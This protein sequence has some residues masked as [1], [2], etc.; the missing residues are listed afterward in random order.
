M[1]RQA[2]ALQQ[3]QTFIAGCGFIA[4]E[5]FDLRQRQVLD[6]RQ[7]REQFE[8]LEHHADVRTQL[9]QIRF[10]VVHL[11]AVDQDFALLHR[12]QAVNGFN[13]GGFTGAGRPAYHHHFAFFHFRGAVGQHL[14]VTIPF[15]N[16]FQGNHYT[17][18]FFK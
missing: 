14:K 17:V 5:H 15:R 4:L 7:V 9:C 13:Q 3:L 16:I 8:M 10:L 2:N 18:L 6:N 12:F 11:R 1:R